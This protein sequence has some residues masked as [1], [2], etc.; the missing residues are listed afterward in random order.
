MTTTPNSIVTPQ[1]PNR[2]VAQ[3]TNSSSTSTATTLFTAGGNGSKI[4][5]LTGMNS[6]TSSH[7]VQFG[8]VNGG[9]FYPIGTVTLASGAGNSGSVAGINLINSSQVPGLP[10][11]SDGNPYIYLISGDTLG[12][13]PVTAPASGK[14]ITLACMDGDF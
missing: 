10:I 1:T 13:L 2:G 11:D 4:V 5:S 7:D 6:D 14:T 8:I 3:L 9:T 12:V